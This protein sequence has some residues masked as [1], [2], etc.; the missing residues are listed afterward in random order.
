[1]KHTVSLSYLCWQHFSKLM[2]HNEFPF[3]NEPS[4]KDS[5]L[6]I[7]GLYEHSHSDPPNCDSST[8]KTNFK[9]FVISF[10]GIAMMEI[11]G[12][13]HVDLSQSH[14]FY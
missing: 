13:D 9:N 3:R 1:M 7:I 14:V 8:V 2:K 6:K 11:D 12:K 10:I 4:V 5:I